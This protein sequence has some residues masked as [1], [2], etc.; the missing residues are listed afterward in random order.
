MADVRRQLEQMLNPTQVA[1]AQQA[2]SIEV[3]ADLVRVNFNLMS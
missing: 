2:N 1:Q 3:L